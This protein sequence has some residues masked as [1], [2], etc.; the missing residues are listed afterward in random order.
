MGRSSDDP[1]LC[2]MQEWSI[3]KQLEQLLREVANH[4]ANQV[5]RKQ[6]RLF[7]ED[8]M[9]RLGFESPNGWSLLCHCM[10]LIGDCEVAKANFNRFGLSGP[11]RYNDPG[12]AHLR[13]Y[14]ILNCVYQ[15]GSAL[16]ELFELFKLSGKSSVEVKF[17][18]LQ[19]TQ[20]RHMAG[21]HT[22]NFKVNGSRRKT[23][24]TLSRPGL[25]QGELVLYDDKN[26]SYSWDIHE[27]LKAYSQW[28]EMVLFSICEKAIGAAFR[29]SQNDLVRYK[30]KLNVIKLRANG[31]VVDADDDGNILMH[32]QLH[33]RT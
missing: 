24:F 1:N 21:A 3:I 19:I 2:R 14:G 22:V 10:D 18:G 12:E 9:R 25:H 13:L 26:K 27:A 8:I 17:Q 5:S 6:K 29:T 20:L 16:K 32:I 33:N 11:T 7:Q 15:E 31:D 4:V 30:A 23:S 28:A